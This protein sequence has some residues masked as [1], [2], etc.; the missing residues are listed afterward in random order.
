MDNTTHFFAQ[1][2]FTKQILISK[3]VIDSINTGYYLCYY[4]R[5]CTPLPPITITQII[6]VCFSIFNPRYHACIVFLHE[7]DLLM[8][9][10]FTWI[11]FENTNLSL[12]ILH[13]ITKVRNECDL[14]LFVLQSFANQF[15]S[16]EILDLSNNL[17]ATVE[18]MVIFFLKKSTD[19]HF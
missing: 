3:F 11:W 16:L 17:I 10:D 8:P 15:P 19:L 1:K 14:V 18:E 2:K 5:K 9:V 13:F 4:F 12:Q 6:V 7:S